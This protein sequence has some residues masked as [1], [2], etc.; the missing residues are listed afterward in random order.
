[1]KWMQSLT[2]VSSF[3]WTK[4]GVQKIANLRV[5]SKSNQWDK[6][7]ELTKLAISAFCRAPIVFTTNRVYYMQLILVDHCPRQHQ[8]L[9]KL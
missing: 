8:H 6:V 9:Y 3:E 7:V 1:M 5:A 4:K 2:G